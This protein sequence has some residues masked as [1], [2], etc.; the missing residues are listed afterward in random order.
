MNELQGRYSINYRWWRVGRGNVK[1]AH[2]DELHAV[3][4]QHAQ[5]Q[6]KEGY[7]EGDLTTTVHRAGEKVDTGYRGAWSY[8][9]G[10]F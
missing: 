7:R 5:E 8:Y 2:V 6:I 9:E 4:I 10:V 3:A 1:K